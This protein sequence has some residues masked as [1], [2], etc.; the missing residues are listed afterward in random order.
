MRMMVFQASR[1]QLLA[2]LV[3]YTAQYEAGD[4]PTITIR[5]SSPGSGSSSQKADVSE[6]D[7]IV[8]CKSPSEDSPSI[9]ARKIEN[10][11][12]AAAAADQEVKKMEFWSDVKDIARKGGSVGAEA[13]Q[14]GW[15][16]LGISGASMGNE[17]LFG[18]AGNCGEKIDKGKGKEVVR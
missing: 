15:G 1:R 17:K 14:Q 8:E 13:E 9:R 10:L 11:K 18:G 6:P 16:D 7:T 3:S 2:H 5:P 4:V 12:K